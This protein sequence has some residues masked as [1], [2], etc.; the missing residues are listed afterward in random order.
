MKYE[1]PSLDLLARELGKPRVGL[2]QRRRFCLKLRV[3]CVLDYVIMIHI[4]ERLLLVE[5]G[6]DD[7]PLVDDDVLVD[8]LG[9]VRLR[10]QS[11]QLA[12]L[13]QVL[14]P[15]QIA[16]LSKSAELFQTLA[17]IFE[18]KMSSCLWARVLVVFPVLFLFLLIQGIIQHIL[19]K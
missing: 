16:F 18:F 5:I 3:W 17:N 7:R 2:R 15:F 6:Y 14:L 8:N 19:S 12:L 13:L 11:L 10:L 4:G 1:G 9:T